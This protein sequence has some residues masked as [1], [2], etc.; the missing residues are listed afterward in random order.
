MQDSTY[1]PWQI[2]ELAGLD[3]AGELQ[4]RRL[5]AA[6]CITPRTSAASATSAL[7]AAARSALSE[8]EAVQR[9][10]GYAPSTAV[11]ITDLVAA[12]GVAEGGAR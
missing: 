6:G 2:E 7:L 11:V 4:G 10:D 9:H 12:I 5:F 3:A 8:L 1:A